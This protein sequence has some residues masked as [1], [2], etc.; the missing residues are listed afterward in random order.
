MSIKITQTDGYHL[1]QK[2]NARCLLP[3]LQDPIPAQGVLQ[4]FGTGHAHR[5]VCLVQWHAKPYIVKYDQERER[6]P[7]KIVMNAL[8]GSFYARLMRLTDKAKQQG[9]QVFQDVYAVKE[10][11]RLRISTEAVAVYEYV[12][13]IPLNQLPNRADY[14]AQ[15][16]ACVLQ[17]HAAGLAS[18]DLH[19]GNFILTPSGD[20]RI[21]DLSC[22]GSIKVCQAN[23]VLKLQRYLD[24]E[25]DGHG[26][27]YH[28]IRWKEAWR[29]KRRARRQQRDVPSSDDAK[30]G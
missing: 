21:I 22:K 24:P 27:V 15:I 8:C 12:E 1:Y 5:S 6:R 4:V 19:Y 11:R 23:D 25:L 14:H 26:W 3:L 29:A 20:I 18:N 13:G 16:I 10:K 2:S 9:C 7:E 17:L 28:L 30:Q